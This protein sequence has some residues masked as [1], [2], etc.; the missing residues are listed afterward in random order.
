MIERLPKR[1]RGECCKVIEMKVEECLK[2]IGGEL[3][4]GAGTKVF[5]G[6]SID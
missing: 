6:V 5:R 2:A 4:S 3:V 1:Q